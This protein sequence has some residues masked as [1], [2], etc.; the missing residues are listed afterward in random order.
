MRC[1][2]TRRDGCCFLLDFP[3]DPRDM[4][5]VN[6]G[7]EHLPDLD[8]QPVFVQHCKIVVFPSDDLGITRY[9]SVGY[10]PDWQHIADTGDFLLEGC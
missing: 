8:S 5:R 6:V 3:Y 10:R 1:E 4:F 2:G 9:S 7:I